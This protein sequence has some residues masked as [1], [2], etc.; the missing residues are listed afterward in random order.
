MVKV[1]EYG[2]RYTGEPYNRRFRR[3]ECVVIESGAAASSVARR[4]CEKKLVMK[5][6]LR[7][8]AASVK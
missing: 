7:W 8:S 2:D 4:Q 3:N 1:Y 5:V 6:E